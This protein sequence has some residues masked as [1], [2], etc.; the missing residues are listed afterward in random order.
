[1]KKIIKTFLALSMVATFA[2]KKK[3]DPEPIISTPSDMVE[4]SGN[5]STQTLDA[6]KQ[7]LIK[8]QVFVNDGQV[9]TIPAGTILKGDKASKG[10]LVIN[11]GGKLMAEGTA[12]SPIVFTSSR[13][14]GGRDKGDWGGI[15]MLGRANVN[16]NGPKIE[17]ISPEVAYGTFN[18]T[19]Y[20]TE[21]SGILKFVRVEYAGIAL[22]PNNETNSITMGGIGSGTT[23]ENVQVSFGGDD[24]FEWFG[25]VVNCKNL[26]SLGTWDD[27]FDCDYG[28]SGNVQYALAIRDPF[29]ADQSTSNAFEADNNG[30]GSTQTPLTQAVFSNV[31]VLGPRSDSATSISSTYGSAMHLKK[32]TALSIFNSVF[33]GFN[34]GVLIDGDNTYSNYT[35]GS[36]VLDHNIIAFVKK[37]TSAP[38]FYGAAG[39]HAVSDVQTYWGTTKSNTV[40]TIATN[41]SKVADWSPLGLSESLFYAEN[42]ASYPVNPDFTVSAGTLSSG[43]TFT[44]A[45]LSGGFFAATTHRG[46]FGATDW[47]DGWANFSP[48]NADY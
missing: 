27:D 9:L 37:G 5:L 29:A 35:G 13:E 34:T 28:F 22:S 44:D 42:G 32:T 17:G 46:A 1:M 24:G 15:V 31:T 48:Q 14:K 3:D 6:S 41:P 25:G 21:S 23:V 18:A 40:V 39:A 33:T 8:G 30:S 47:T 12:A 36:G 38:A 11:L 4:L 20:N 16:Q 26:I 43:G 2:C 10:T 19:T 7:Y 45:K